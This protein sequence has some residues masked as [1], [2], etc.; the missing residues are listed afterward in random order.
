MIT[1]LD[2]MDEGTDAREILEN[3]LLPL[4]RGEH[5]H[6]HYLFSA[7]GLSVTHCFPLVVVRQSYSKLFK[8][9]TTEKK[10]E[11]GKEGGTDDIIK[12]YRVKNQRRSR[13]VEEKK[14]WGGKAGKG[15][16]TEKTLTWKRACMYLAGCPLL[17]CADVVLFFSICTWL[18]P[19]HV[20]LN[21]FH[22]LCFFYVFFPLSSSPSP[23]LFL[24]VFN[25]VDVHIYKAAGSQLH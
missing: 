5:T 2:L 19:R 21:I 14:S 17:Q 18:R 10:T 8:S 3:K 20:L 6:T 7:S 11:E 4:R 15:A 1:K 25:A 13:K 24:S 12:Q 22:V 9:P 23:R 16:K